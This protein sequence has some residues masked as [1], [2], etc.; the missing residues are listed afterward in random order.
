MKEKDNIR[1]FDTSTLA[2]TPGIRQRCQEDYLQKALETLLPGEKFKVVSAAINETGKYQAKLNWLVKLLWNNGKI[3]GL[4]PFCEVQIAHSTGKETETIVVWSPLAW[5]DRFAGTAGG[6]T[7]TGGV[8]QIMAPDNGQR[9]W[10]LP[11]AVI[12]GFTASTC[13]AGNDRYGSNWASDP[14]GKIVWERVENWR[15]NAT[16][17]MTVFGKAIAEI[18]HDRPVR[19]AYMNGGSGGGRQ[20]MV[21]VQEYPNDYDGV[22]AS[23]PAINWT[24]FIITGFWPMAVAREFHAPLKYHKLNAFAKAVQE[25]VGG[26]EQYY[27]LHDKVSFDPFSLV[28]Q[29]TKQGK[30]TKQDAQVVQE[31]WDGPRRKN[32]ERLW[33]GFRPGLIHWKTGLPI[34]SLSFIFPFSK[35]RPFA[36]CN[37]WVRWVEENPKFDFSHIDIAA[38]EKLFDSSVSVFSKAAADRADV[39][40]FASHGGKL[41]IDHGL[42]DPLIQVDGTID[43]FD[44]MKQAMGIDCVKGFCRVYL[45]PGDNHGNCRGNGPGITEC[46]GMRALIDWVEKGIAPETIR[47]VQLDRKT[48][49]ML[50]ESLL[51]PVSYEVCCKGR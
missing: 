11:F 8:N 20:S 12:N 33:Y 24:K 38:F 1:F 2:E 47:T 39:S 28:G 23:S 41:I 19:Y 18:L 26:A 37:T 21:E 15:A 22:W 10:T 34:F 6:G 46:D 25:S 40:A 4:P 49:D 3:S 50:R 36:L 44:R 7:C 31:M 42:D 29:D 17:Q 48:G 5:N 43:Y 14:N 35:G 9:G 30:I 51:D 45:G 16:H 13:D 27:Q 32:G